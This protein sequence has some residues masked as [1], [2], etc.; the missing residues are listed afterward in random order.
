MSAL[1]IFAIF[2][3]FGFGIL[4]LI[5]S[6]AILFSAAYARDVSLYVIAGVLG[7]SSLSLLWLSW[8][9]SPW[10]IVREAS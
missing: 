3:T 1:T 5:L 4:T 9:L 8:S 2:A 7:M 6:G 10:T